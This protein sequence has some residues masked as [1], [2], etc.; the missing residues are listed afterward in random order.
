MQGSGLHA[1]A[2][3]RLD[4]PIAPLPNRDSELEANGSGLWSWGSVAS[5]APPVKNAPSSS[6]S[7]RQ[8]QSH[9]SRTRDTCREVTS[10]SLSSQCGAIEAAE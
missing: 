2:G 6:A 10:A 7:R 1:A 8:P 4:L 5:I 9:N 3:T